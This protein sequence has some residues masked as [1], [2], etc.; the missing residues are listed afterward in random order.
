IAAGVLVGGAGGILNGVLVTV[1]KVPSLIA[2]LGTASIASG[3][4]F[5][6]TGGVAYVGHWSEAFLFLARGSLF[7]VPVLVVVTVVALLASI[8]ASETMRIGVHM[9]ATGEAP[10][11]AR[12]AGVSVR[13]MKCA[14][15]ALSGMCA[16]I[17]AVLLVA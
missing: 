2:T 6:L 9:R 16:G 13:G 5:M 4:A 12:R 17:T 11:A 8:L 14:G 7:S 3:T 10:E 1:L 15:L